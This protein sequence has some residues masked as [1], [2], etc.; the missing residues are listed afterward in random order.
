M[1]IPIYMKYYLR[2]KCGMYNYTNSCILLVVHLII[3]VPFLFCVCRVECADI[4]QKKNDLQC[5]SD[6]FKSKTFKKNKEPKL[7]NLRQHPYNMKGHIVEAL[8]MNRDSSYVN[9]GK[10]N[11][12]LHKKE[13]SDLQQTPPETFLQSLQNTKEEEPNSLVQNMLFIL[14]KNEPALENTEPYENLELTIDD[15]ELDN[16]IVEVLGNDNDDL[17][18]EM[19]IDDP[20]GFST[21]DTVLDMLE[22][23]QKQNNLEN[24][25][26]TIHEVFSTEGLIE[27]QPSCSSSHLEEIS[28]TTEFY[29]DRDNKKEESSNE[30]I[31]SEDLRLKLEQKP[32]FTRSLYLRKFRSVVL[33]LHHIKTFIKET[34]EIQI[35]DVKRCYSNIIK[36]YLLRINHVISALS[37]CYKTQAY[38]QLSELFKKIY[39]I[40]T[41]PYI[42]EFENDAFSIIESSTSMEI[43]FQ[44]LFN[45]NTRS[46][47]R[48]KFIL[49]KN[50]NENKEV[51]KNFLQN[52]NNLTKN[53][54][55]LTDMFSKLLIPIQKGTLLYKLRGFYTIVFHIH[56]LS[57]ESVEGTSIFPIPNLLKVIC[58]CLHDLRHNLDKLKKC[59]I[60]DISKQINEYIEDEKNGSIKYIRDLLILIK[61]KKKEIKTK[62]KNNLTDPKIMSNYLYY[63]FSFL[64]FQ[65]FL[66][67]HKNIIEQQDCTKVYKSFIDV[68]DSYISKITPLID[69][70]DL[71]ESEKY[72]ICSNDE[73]ILCIFEYLFLEMVYIILSKV[74][75][76]CKAYFNTLQNHSNN[77]NNYIGKHKFSQEIA[78]LADCTTSL[79]ILT[80]GLQIIYKH[81]YLTIIFLRLFMVVNNMNLKISEILFLLKHEN[82]V[83]TSDKTYATILDNCT[84]IDCAY[85]E[86]LYI[87]ENKLNYF[88]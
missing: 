25:S 20:L 29:T 39:E 6:N 43:Y 34:N 75:K 11:E 74:D 73:S 53:V 35:E 84:D 64:M 36:T 72:I 88:T 16:I 62:I 56:D 54:I 26:T 12:I 37:P 44:L 18:V 2:K 8:V 22:N 60:I 40:H 50:Y 15:N 31:G 48:H 14:E 61:G 7:K 82:Q 70:N 27:N 49:K 65:R 45:F 79:D 32:R 68:W 59:K 51:F 10:V 58:K 28:V 52:K 78:M 71:S 66:N 63:H 9:R 69:Y 42:C 87:M 5:F 85:K 13:A 38:F 67:T 19:F 57:S 1:N 81:K 80:A 83:Y 17:L 33:L 46:I 47:S 77:Q 3:W 86:F 55:A 76:T 4:E 21:Y 23:T 30:N 41:F 24:D